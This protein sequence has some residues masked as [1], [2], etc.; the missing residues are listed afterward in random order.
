M[1]DFDSPERMRRLNELNLDALKHTYAYLID[2]KYPDI[3][4][5]PPGYFDLICIVRKA[6]LKSNIEEFT[7]PD[8]K[9]YELM[10]VE[11]EV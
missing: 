5:E 6:L 11:G 1:G 9:K 2:N 8:G 7:L 3:K 4:S 10:P